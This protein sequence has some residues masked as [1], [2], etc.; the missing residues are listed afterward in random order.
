MALLEKLSALPAPLRPDEGGVLRV[1][2]TR[3]RL[4]TVIGAFNTGSSAEEIL[5]KYPSLDLTDIYSVITYYLWH[6][7]E[8]DAY[9]LDREQAARAT[10]Q[11]VEV[12]F[13]R[14][15]VRERLLA[16]RSKPQG[17]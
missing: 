6:R 13:P 9:L 11:E 14:A 8:V 15:G 3:V 7:G 1:G 2:Q 4:D 17:L 12:R 16:R 10:Q 5:L